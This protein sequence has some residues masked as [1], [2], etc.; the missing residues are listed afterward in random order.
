MPSSVRQVYLGIETVTER[1][2]STALL[3]VMHRWVDFSTNMIFISTF[4]LFFLIK[5]II[6]RYKSFTF[7][8]SFVKMRTLLDP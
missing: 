4:L 3:E 5:S 7:Y 1:N 2:T 6:I 8:N